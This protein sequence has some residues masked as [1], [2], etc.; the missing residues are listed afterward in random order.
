MSNIIKFNKTRSVK[1]PNNAYG[2]YAAATDFFC[3][4]YDPVFYTDLV[5]KNPNMD[6]YECTVSPNRDSMIIV[7]A[8]NGRINIPPGI[9]VII[10]DEDT[11]LLAVNKSGIAA[12]K[13]LVLG[14][15]LIDY[16]V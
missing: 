2:G 14:A 10:N 12:N 9:R 1:T 4:D 11:C 5:N 3:P 13:G 8:P 16:W 7:I 15:C 6:Y